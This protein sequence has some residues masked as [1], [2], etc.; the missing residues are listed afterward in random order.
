ME[1]TSGGGGRAEQGLRSREIGI[2]PGMWE[3][4]RKSNVFSDFL[5]AIPASADRSE[6]YDYLKRV[7]TDIHAYITR[8]KINV[9]IHNHALKTCIRRVS[10]HKHMNY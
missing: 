7:Y 2:A 6:G 10:I 8:S 1:G 5:P 4:V 9:C 3:R